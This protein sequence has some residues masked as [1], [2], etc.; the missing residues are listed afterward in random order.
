[1]RLISSYRRD[2]QQLPTFAGTSVIGQTREIG[3]DRQRYF[4]GESSILYLL[5]TMF[6]FDPC[7]IFRDIN[8]SE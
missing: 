3:I 7:R 5:F 4:M 8:E 1:M 2:A 6:L